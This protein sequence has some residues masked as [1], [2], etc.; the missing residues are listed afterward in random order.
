[1]QPSSSQIVG[2][3]SADAD[4]AQ[5]LGTRHGRV[6]ASQK[7]NLQ[8]GQRGQLSL[9]RI[10]TDKNVAA[11]VMS[12]GAVMPG[13][14]LACPRP[15]NIKRKSLDSSLMTTTMMMMTRCNFTPASSILCF[16]GPVRPPD[17]TACPDISNE[18]KIHTADANDETKACHSM[19]KASV[20][21]V[22]MATLH[23]VNRPSL[24]LPTDDGMTR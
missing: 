20:T 5:T 10:G 22:A 1:M 6:N 13:L 18:N 19:K 9:Q 14:G 17:L 23:K 16:L 8:K 7:P 15:R 11:F 4:C 2:T 12:F 21:A 3:K 24:C